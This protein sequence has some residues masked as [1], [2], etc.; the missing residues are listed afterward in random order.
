MCR[1][2]LDSCYCELDAISLI[3][4]EKLSMLSRCLWSTYLDETT[5]CTSKLYIQKKGSCLNS[6]NCIQTYFP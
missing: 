6:G 4:K 3:V 5:K 2:D 1:K